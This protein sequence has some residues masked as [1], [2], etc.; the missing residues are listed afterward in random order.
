MDTGGKDGTIRK[1]LSGIN[2]AG[3]RVTSFKVPSRQELDH[4]FL[5]RTHKA[6]PPKGI[7]G[8]WSRSP[9]EDVLVVRVRKL[10]ERDIW[11][12]RF[13]QI[14]SFEKIL[15]S[16]GTTIVKFMLHISKDEQERRLQARLDN[17]EKWWK[18]SPSDLKERT[19]W[20]DYQEAYEE[21][22]NRCSTD[23]A[24]WHVVPANRKWARDLA[25]IELLFRVFKRMDPH[26]PKLT[27]DPKAVTINPQQ[28]VD[29]QKLKER[30]KDVACPKCCVATQ[31]VLAYRL[32]GSSDLGLS[33][34]S[35]GCGLARQRP[36][37]SRRERDRRRSQFRKTPQKFTASPVH[38][39][40]SGYGLPSQTS[41]NFAVSLT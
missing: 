23:F 25:V 6:T 34:L 13:D 26:Y 9:Y 7:I 40:P 39:A 33:A 32:S 29:Q 22:I 28:P 30:A 38:V 17:P 14:N 16:N 10:I 20:D 19:F 41:G 24:P 3:I 35:C 11:K 37:S 5:W 15:T 1:L 8:V 36:L 27:F 18:F 12:S 31:N 4:D 2:P 21:A